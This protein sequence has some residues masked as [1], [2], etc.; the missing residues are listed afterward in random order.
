MALPAPPKDGKRQRKVYRSK[1]R[2]LV[3]AKLH[4]FERRQRGTYSPSA[5][6]Y[7]TGEGTT[8]AQWF[9]YWLAECAGPQLRPKTIE[10][11][12]YVTRN[13]ILPALGP[14]TPLAAVRASDV[15]RLHRM[16]LEKHSSTTARNAHVVAARAFD[17]AV[18]EE[19]IPRNPV[20]LVEPPRKAFVE[21][22]VPTLSELRGL[23]QMLDGHPD[24]ARWATYI[25]TGAR[26]GEVLGLELDRVADHLV[27]SW[28]LQ[29]L[30][31][32]PNG[33]P[34]AAP[35]FEYR[36]LYGG[37]YLT[38]PKSRAGWRTVPLI[39]PLASML[40]RHIAE[41]EPNPWGLVFTNNGRPIDPD[42]ETKNWPKV[43]S[44]FFGPERRVR[45]HDL[46]HAAVDLLY[47]ADVPEEL[48]IELVGHTTR[49]MTRAYKSPAHLERLS[50]AMSGVTE[51]LI[52][53][54]D[55]TD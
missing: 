52:E 47:A 36:H 15:R 19:E 27:I 48:I 29:R 40:R 9:D 26:R 37:Y 41:S 43:A 1:D 49:T 8:V 21:L 12:Q 24:G 54:P 32:G 4:D 55:P 44:Q 14:E 3:L 51:L 16:I 11:Y 7:P 38:R 33:L 2:N 22:D 18:R 25:L 31:R 46:R 6:I 53:T 30:M 5:L 28:Q 39:E 35:D 17:T 34:I 42:K 23:L 20:R 45:L 13:W 50:R 10:G